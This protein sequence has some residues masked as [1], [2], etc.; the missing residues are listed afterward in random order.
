MPDRK[1]MEGRTK[2]FINEL[3]EFEKPINHI[4]KEFNKKCAYEGFPM[5]KIKPKYY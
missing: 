2:Y 3:L 5:K 4:F 1:K